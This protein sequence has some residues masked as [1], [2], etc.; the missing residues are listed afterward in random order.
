MD[1]TPAINAI[2]M[3]GVGYGIGTLAKTNPQ[4]TALAF[5]IAEIAVQALRFI[6]GF[7]KNRWENSTRL[8]LGGIT[9]FYLSENHYINKISHAILSMVAFGLVPDLLK[10]LYVY[11][12]LDIQW[13]VKKGVVI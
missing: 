7:D 6:D 8:I 13:G 10:R 12:N 5:V 1:I 9:C 2:C 4:I 11:V 3:G